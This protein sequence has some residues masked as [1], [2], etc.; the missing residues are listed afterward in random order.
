MQQFDYRARALVLLVTCTIFP[1]VS[2][3]SAAAE[4]ASRGEQEKE[5]SAF[6]YVIDTSSSMRY[7]FD[8]LRDVVKK[9]VDH[10]APND[11]LSIILFGDSVQTLVSYSSVTPSKKKFIKKSLDSI[12]PDALY[13]NLGLA[14]KRSTEVLHSYA[15][16][17]RA[18]H[19][20]LILVT[21]GKDHPPPDFVRDYS[22]EE[23]LARSADF[24][25]G[26]QW[27]LHYVVLKG[28]IDSEL[29]GV[30]E[31][32]EGTFLDVDQI[33]R[34]SKASE[35][36]VI[37]KILESL[38][39]WKQLRSI[40]IQHDGKVKVKKRDAGKWLK[41][42]EGKRQEI[43]Y[44]DRVAVGK[45]SSAVIEF[46]AFGKI[47]IMDNAEVG[48]DHINQL[49][50]SESATIRLN[51]DG[52]TV[53]NAIESAPGYTLEYEVL[54]PIALTGVRGTVF[55][56]SFDPTSREQNIAVLDGKVQIR[57]AEEEERQEQ[58]FV[59]ESGTSSTFSSAR[60][61]PPS[62]SIPDKIILEWTKWR[63]ILKRE[64]PDDSRQPIAFDFCRYV[65]ATEE[66]ECGAVR[67]LAF[68]P[69]G[70]GATLERHLT[71]KTR[72]IDVT[73]SPRVFAALDI[74]PPPWIRCSVDIEMDNISDGIVGLLVTVRIEEGVRVPRGGEWTGRLVLTSPNPTVKF[75]QDG[76][77]PIRIFG[78]GRR[79]AAQTG[80]TIFKLQMKT[81][82]LC[83]RVI[84]GVC[85]VIVV[86][87]PV[88]RYGRR[89]MRKIHP[90]QLN[91]WLLVT[92]CPLDADVDDIDLHRLG[93]EKH[94][95]A[96]VMGR[97]D[98]ADIQLPHIS[99][100]RTHALVYGVKRASRIR[101]YIKTIGV[102]KLEINF[103]PI[104]KTA[105]E[106]G[107]RDV[108]E[109][110]S[111]QFLYTVSHLQRVVVHF[112]DGSTKHGVL[113]TWNMESD[114]FTLLPKDQT[115]GEMARH[116]DFSELK[117]IFFVQE[118]DREIAVKIRKRGKPKG[119]GHIVV[120]FLDGEKIEGHVIG[121][122]TP[123]MPRFLVAPLP[124]KKE[125][126]NILY[127]LVERSFTKK[128]SLITE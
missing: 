1:I 67:E 2:A 71:L 15:E 19:Y 6:V 90:I 32:Y 86:M 48:L 21:D 118:Y 44:G 99:V 116:V 94:R 125:D 60:E 76:I 68:G 9:A 8:D 27:S 41:I 111:F 14:I 74:V 57:S 101:M 22:I 112:K 85:L 65:P 40:I 120:E 115:G 39:E 43:F 113:Q 105:V 5:N 96:L 53:W 49:P 70:A 98:R 26:N 81:V 31:K 30:V 128:I 33:V 13:T 50:I 95:S 84:I 82:W 123:D 110:G 121:R 102:S 126:Q 12:Y 28:Q 83:V 61:R 63:E 114:G 10:C 73:E 58:G 56:L 104:Y 88:G 92:G 91:G 38:D 7:I 108:I 47:G 29:L 79:H 35:K 107:D 100:D 25:P 93:S 59:I 77:I 11:C 89:I 42:P 23:V 55:K 18:S 3:F 54:T 75:S 16:D 87:R 97:G 24:L 122:Y 37:G 64:I 20:R 17:D 109:I 46:G 119:K 106:L 66:Y 78:L 80:Q 62:L 36:D 51:L 34:L 124:K 117:G 127:V 45:G 69:I 72:E 52:G 103:S 4:E